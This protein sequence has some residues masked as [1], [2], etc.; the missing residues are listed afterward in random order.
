MDELGTYKIRPAG[1]H[2]LTIGEGLIQDQYAAII[3]LVKNAYDADSDDISICFRSNENKDFLQICIEDHG[4]GM[5]NYDVVNKWLVP[6]TDY[7]LKERKSPK[8]RIM[9]GRKGIGRYAASILGDDLLL[10]TVTK[11]GEKTELYIEWDKFKKHEYLDQVEILVETEYVEELSGTSL[12]INGGRERINDWSDLSLNK[13]RFELKKLIPPK[14]D[15]TFDETFKIQL[16]FEKFFEGQTE[17]IIENIT[18]YPIL[19][20][21]DYRIS[22]MIDSKGLGSLVYQNQKI[23]N[24]IEEEFQID[25]SETGCGNLKVDIRVYDR[26]KDAIEQLIKRGLKDE[27]TGHYISKLETRRL[28]NEVNGIGVYRNGFRIR[29]L[30]DADFDW[31]K[32]NEQRVQNPSLRIGSNQVVGYVHIESEEISNL[33]EKSA[34]DGLKNNLAYERLKEITCKVIAE[35]ENRRFIFRRKIGLSNPIKKIERNIEELYNY[36][37]LI[38][39]ISSS[40]KKA[41]SS[42]VVID[43]IENIISK[44]QNEKNEVVEEIK[45]SVAVYQGQATLG[46]IVNIILHEGRRPLNYFRNQ[47]PN[48]KFY[49]DKFLT[50]PDKAPV[51]KINYLTS[52][53]TE[54][55]GVLV[56]LFSRLD[57]L[58][59]KR[60]ETKAEFSLLD[61]LNGVVSVFENEFNYKNISY[62]INC[63]KEVKLFGWKQDFYAIFTNLIDNSIFWIEEKNCIERHISIEVL[64]IENE[65]QINYKDTGPGIDAELLESQVIFE[66]EFTTKTNG[67]GL[68]LAI[69]G[70]AAKRNGLLLIALQ[71]DKGAYF[72]LSTEQ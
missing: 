65:L 7:K 15:D 72:N 6:S 66:P 19:D 30:G 54:N 38:K 51:E 8:G 3:E 41:G 13:L 10:K 57:P 5:S 1:K 40:L 35:L 56:T 31:L 36:S 60:R 37:S 21:F 58:A 52:G 29:P 4:H 25:F 20:L 71:D 26:D 45:R 59:A 9:Q 32:L 17:V 33:E 28:L 22:G 39:S 64:F 69:A 34:R 42:Q 61:T 44:E 63:S 24:G 23:R 2:V 47:I 53:I 49:L 70:E 18:P 43:E 68:G 55:A 50:E 11:E 62:S 46:K 14:T 16:C 48:L 12:T 27:N 67:T